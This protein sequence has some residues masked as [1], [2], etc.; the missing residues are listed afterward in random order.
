[1]RNK[2]KLKDAGVDKR[3]IKARSKKR[4]YSKE[5][6]ENIRGKLVNVKEAK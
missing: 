5:I 6:E 3:K 4:I 2:R 1:M